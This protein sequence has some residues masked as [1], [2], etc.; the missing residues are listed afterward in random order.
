MYG[1]GS[2]LPFEDGRTCEEGMTR[3]APSRYKTGRNAYTNHGR[4]FN[5]ESLIA[6]KKGA[7]PHLRLL[8]PWEVEQVSEEETTAGA[9]S[10]CRIGRSAHWGWFAPSLFVIYYVW[11]EQPGLAPTHFP[12]TE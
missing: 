6:R 11:K 7:I 5:C 9:A 12:T 2:L 3:R 4:T 10:S 1:P 8:L